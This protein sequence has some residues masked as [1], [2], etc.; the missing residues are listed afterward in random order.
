MYHLGKGVR[1]SGIQNV[2]FCFYNNS[3]FNEIIF[4]VF[5]FTLFLSLK[6]VKNIYIFEKENIIEIKTIDDRCLHVAA[7]F[8]NQSSKKQLWMV[9]TFQSHC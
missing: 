3:N 4:F 8:V 5:R 6:S 1:D 2:R 9:A 7:L